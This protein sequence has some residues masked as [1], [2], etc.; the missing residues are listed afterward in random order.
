M[1]YLILSL[2][3]KLNL[4]VSKFL[5]LVI[6]CDN[7]MSPLT[8]LVVLTSHLIILILYLVVLLSH[9]M[10]IYTINSVVKCSQSDSQTNIYSITVEDPPY[11]VFPFLS[12]RLYYA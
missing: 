9:T 1:K 6:C 7:T 3:E 11:L 12:R 4:K 10:Y 5:H 2:C 8:H